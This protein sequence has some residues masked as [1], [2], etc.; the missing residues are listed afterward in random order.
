MQAVSGHTRVRTDTLRRGHLSAASASSDKPAVSNHRRSNQDEQYVPHRHVYVRCGC[1]A[2]RIHMHHTHLN[3]THG[4]PSTHT[5]RQIHMLAMRTRI[6]SIAR[7]GKR[8]GISKVSLL[9]QAQTRSHQNT[10][11]PTY[12]LSGL[13]GCFRLQVWLVPSAGCLDLELE[14]GFGVH[15]FDL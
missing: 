15:T 3:H 11:V 1:A 7:A 9:R 10:F 5:Y 2:T 13:D 6:R 14:L 4:T 8:A 12:Q